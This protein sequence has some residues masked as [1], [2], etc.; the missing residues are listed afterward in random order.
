MSGLRKRPWVL[1]IAGFGFLVGSLIFGS[2]SLASAGPN[3]PIFTANQGAPG[4]S[5]WPVAASGTVNVGN[6]PA[7]QPVSGTVNVGNLPA[8]QKVAGLSDVVTS[9]SAQTLL[10]RTFIDTGSLNTTAYR[11]LRLY[12]NCTALVSSGDCGP[13]VVVTLYAQGGTKFTLDSFT[14]SDNTSVTRVED[15]P[16]TSINIE[17]VNTAVNDVKLDYSVIGRTN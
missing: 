12:F 13:G 2:F 11:S 10:A 9:A 16:G 8:V 17:I 1:W 14:L 5:P 15:V 6:L 7:T 3:P 4:A